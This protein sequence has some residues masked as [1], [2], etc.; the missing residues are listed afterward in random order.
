MS[1]LIKILHREFTLFQ[2]EMFE[3]VSLLIKPVRSEIKSEWKNCFTGLRWG[4]SSCKC[5]NTLL[6]RTLIISVLKK[7]FWR[8]IKLFIVL[9]FFVLN[10]LEKLLPSLN[11]LKGQFYL[12]IRSRKYWD[13]QD[14]Q[15]HQKQKESKQQ[16]QK[17]HFSLPGI[18]AQ[19]WGPKQTNPKKIHYIKEFRIHIFCVFLS[20]LMIPLGQNS[21]IFCDFLSLWISP[22]ITNPCN[23]QLKMSPWECI[24]SSSYPLNYW[25]L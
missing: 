5:K 23:N 3:N 10:S 20:L 2:T 9:F 24:F 6:W 18:K 4:A 11:N 22:S 19:V 21:Y 13:L 7:D 8:R 17:K 14:E 16:C 25:S 1:H 15:G 12:R